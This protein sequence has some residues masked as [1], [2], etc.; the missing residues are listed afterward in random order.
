MDKTNV[1]IAKSGRIEQKAEDA[2][3]CF[4]IVAQTQTQTHNRRLS[5]GW[6]RQGPSAVALNR[7]QL[8]VYSTQYLRGVP[9]GP[10]G[11]ATRGKVIFIWHAIRARCA[12]RFLY[13]GEVPCG[14]LHPPHQQVSLRS[15]YEF[16][17]SCLHG[18]SVCYIEDHVNFLHFN[19]LFC[20]F[21]LIVSYSDMRTREQQCGVYGMISDGSVIV[22]YIVSETGTPPR[23]STQIAGY[24]TPR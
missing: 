13:E 6:R 5:S 1:W 24:T 20:P 7:G 2:V 16:D 11:S 9:T 3:Q 10:G 15:T 4:R 21:C 22:V 17:I 19:P 8:T 14:T 23:I 12:D 18:E